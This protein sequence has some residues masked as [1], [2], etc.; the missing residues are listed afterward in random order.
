MLAVIQGQ[1]TS[2]NDIPALGVN[3]AGNI[4]EIGTKLQQARIGKGFTLADISNVTKMSSHVLQLIE[5]NDFA[6]LPG[7][8]LTRGHLRAFAGEVGLNPEEIVN[9]YR[10]KFESASAEEERF[11]LR[12][13]YQ[14][15][16]SGVPHAGLMLIIGFAILIYFAYPTPVQRPAEIQIA[17]EPAQVNIDEATTINKAVAPSA[18]S[19]HI[20][21][22]PVAAADSDGLQIDLRPQA[23]CWLSAVADGRLVMYRLMQAGERETIV[24]RADIVLR[25]GDAGAL[26]YFVNGRVGRSPGAAGEAVTVRITS[27]NSATWLTDELR[28]D[29][30]NGAEEP[31]TGA[32]EIIPTTRQLTG[33]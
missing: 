28:P 22:S 8:I 32:Q 31:V 27:D 25:V 13:R 9:D 7:G 23:E 30:M 21:S 19:S 17:T 33:I 15:D 26:T 5:T 29:E 10:A 3:H 4:V 16:E 6:Q 2:A 11:K 1:S 20:T 14:S 18:P 12:A 24:A